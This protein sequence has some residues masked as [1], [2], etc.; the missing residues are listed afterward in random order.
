MLKPDLKVYQE[1]KALASGSSTSA[2]AAHQDLYRDANSLVYA[3]HKPSE[4]AIDRVAS[5]LNAEYVFSWRLKLLLIVLLSIDRRRNFS[6]TRVNEK[7]GDITYINEANK[8]FNKKVSRS[9]RSKYVA[10]VLI[11][12]C[13]PRSS[14]TTTSILQKSGRTSKEGLLYNIA[15]SIP[16]YDCSST[17]SICCCVDN[18]L[19]HIRGKLHG[20]HAADPVC[21]VVQETIVDVWNLATDS[22]PRIDL[23]TYRATLQPRCNPPSS[24]TTFIRKFSSN[25]TETEPSCSLLNWARLGVW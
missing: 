2:I 1:Q 18:A 24:L 8:V 13:L 22:S 7:E 4:E 20:S 14:A 21:A 6:K 15:Y 23:L 11:S 9:A 10:R 12:L 3:D 16:I 17:I 19:H 25:H 5:K